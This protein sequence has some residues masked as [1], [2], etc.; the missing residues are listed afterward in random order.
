LLQISINTKIVFLIS[1]KEDKVDILTVI[2]KE[3][4]GRKDGK[5]KLVG[6]EV[7]VLDPRFREF[8][9]S[10]RKWGTKS[11]YSRVQDWKLVWSK[12][13]FEIGQELN[14][15]SFRVNNKL[16]FILDKN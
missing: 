8:T 15:W 6:L 7:I 9:M 10:L 2:E 14:I 5:H 11:V 1:L 16:H 13:S 4:L 3:N 12:N